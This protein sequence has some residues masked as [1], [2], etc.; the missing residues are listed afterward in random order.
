MIADQVSDLIQF[1]IILVG[2]AIVT[3]IVLKHAGGWAAISAAL[4]EKS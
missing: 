1:G 2:L 3:P 4:P